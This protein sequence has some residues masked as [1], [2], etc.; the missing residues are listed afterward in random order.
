MRRWEKPHRR[1]AELLKSA[2]AAQ[3]SKPSRGEP[4]ILADGT[5]RRARYLTGE[6]KHS[7]GGL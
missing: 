7:F 1:A 2:P 5:K 6:Q 4:V 3:A